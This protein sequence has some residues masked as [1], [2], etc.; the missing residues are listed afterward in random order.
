[1]LIMTYGHDID[2]DL[3]RC[4]LTVVESGGFTQASKR[5]HVTQ[6]GITL[7]IKRLEEQL[8]CR[9]F[10]RT[11]KPLELSHEGEIVLGYARRLLDLSQE[12]AQRVA[13]PKTI[14]ALRMGVVDHFGPQL[15]PI[16]LAEFKQ[17]FPNVRIVSDIGLT[18]ELLKD[19]ED[20]KFDLV[21]ASAG[22]TAMGEY[23]LAPS[24]QEIHLQRETMI[25]VQ[26]ENSKIDPSKDPLPLVMFGP[27]C[28]F[29]PIALE[30]LQKAGR[31]WEIMYVGG[32]LNSVHT[33]V[34]AD[35]GLSV[36]SPLS[37]AEG[38]IVPDNAPS[39][40]KLPTADLAI[41]SRKTPS[42]PMVQRFTAFLVKSVAAWEAEYLNSGPVRVPSSVKLGDGRFS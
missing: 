14:D 20:D 38:I 35:L 29:R 33:G 19:L 3:I 30:A 9:L 42:H 37:L 6:S 27:K 7:K 40:P 16:W 24:I 11:T 4:F 15:L 39:L 36:L 18:H 1:M 5:L 17:T 10:R 2:L 23:K 13:K 25:W 34:A 41:Y 8:N 31:T 32:S 21:I 12:M 26:A 28:R 22:Y